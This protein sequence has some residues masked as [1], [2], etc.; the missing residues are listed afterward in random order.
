MLMELQSRL[1]CCKQPGVDSLY[2]NVSPR[3]WSRQ[4][5]CCI[6]SAPQPLTIRE[7]LF[8][9]AKLIRLRWLQQKTKQS[10]KWWTG[11]IWL[12]QLRSYKDSWWLLYSTSPS[13][14]SRWSLW[15]WVAVKPE[16]F[17]LKNHCVCRPVKMWPVKIY[18]P[19]YKIHKKHFMWQSCNIR[20]FLPEGAKLV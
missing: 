15:Q 2:K 8:W 14:P 3:L 16:S 9:L 11:I 7:L 17:P 1:N 18:V 6:T 10:F 13:N 20:S 19:K 12:C 4:I 5:L